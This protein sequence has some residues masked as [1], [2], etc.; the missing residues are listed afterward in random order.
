LFLGSFPIIHR[1]RRETHMIGKLESLGDRLLTRLVPKAQ[2]GAVYCWNVS[3]GGT[4]LVKRCCDVPQ[5]GTRCG[6]CSYVC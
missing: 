3:C 6:S 4:C 2:A 1:T 5:Y